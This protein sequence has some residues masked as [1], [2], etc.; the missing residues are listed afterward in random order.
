MER[1]STRE[2]LKDAL[3]ELAGLDEGVVVIDADVASSTY[4]KT[5]AEE[6]PDRYY[7]VG[8]AEQNMVEV[9]SGMALAGMKPYAVAFSSFLAGRAYDQIRCCVAMPDLNVKLIATHAGIT[10]GEDG[11]THQM[12]EDLALMRALPNMTVMVPADYWSARDLIVSSFKY[13][14]PLYIRLGRMDVPLFYSPKEEFKPGGGK[15]VREGRDVTVIACGIMLFEALKAAE[16]LAHQG[17]EAEVIDC[18]SVKPLPEDLIQSSVR[19]TGCCVVAEEHNQIGG[20]YG[21]VAESLGINYPV[22]L[23]F[24]AIRDRFGES[25]TPAELQEYYSLTHREIVGAVAQVWATRRR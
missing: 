14:K 19:R 2:A 5:F 25:G 12:L 23:R 13:D 8:I 22:P 3:P 4:A 11:G 15:I 9:A 17:I 20:L 16:I 6:F 1:R 21:A 10:V 18:Y 7:N 24:V